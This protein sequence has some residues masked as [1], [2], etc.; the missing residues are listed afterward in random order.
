MVLMRDSFVSRS[1]K[2]LSLSVFEAAKDN[3]CAVDSI[4]IMRKL[5]MMPL[6][7]DD[8]DADIWW[9]WQFQFKF[10]IHTHCNH[11]CILS[12]IWRALSFQPFHQFFQPTL[13]LQAVLE[14]HFGNGCCVRVQ[15]HLWNLFE[16]PDHSK[17]AKVWWW[18]WR[19]NDEVDRDD[20]N[21]DDWSCWWWWSAQVVAVVSCL[22][23]IVSTLCL[24]FSTLPQGLLMVI[25]NLLMMTRMMMM[26]MMMEMKMMQQ[27][28]IRPFFSSS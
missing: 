14:D 19:C 11:S 7:D 1:R 18:G 15:R 27:L 13:V 2:H 26:M 20:D 17:A 5:L 22:F 3:W 23:V 21:D 25:S 16:N 28:L 8:D 9:W 6:H 4:I 10:W 12:L 24:I